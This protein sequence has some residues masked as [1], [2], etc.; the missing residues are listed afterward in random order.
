M[1]DCAG[2]VVIFVRKGNTM[3]KA[4]IVPQEFND[5]PCAS[6]QGFGCGI[7]SAVGRH[8]GN[9]RRGQQPVHLDELVLD[10]TLAVPCEMMLSCTD[11]KLKQ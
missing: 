6:S 8:V 10:G 2:V 4:R 11:L 3:R 5:I 7:P 1:S 9:N